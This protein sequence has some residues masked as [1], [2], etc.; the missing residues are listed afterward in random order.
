MV[1]LNAGAGF[2]RGNLADKSIW[3]RLPSLLPTGES[4]LSVETQVGL[5][6]KAQVGLLP[7]ASVGLLPEASVGLLPEASVGLL[8]EASVSLLPE[9][10]IEPLRI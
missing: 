10:P 2:Y 8:P 3:R 1:G 4:V 5:P 9:A 6:P 7:K